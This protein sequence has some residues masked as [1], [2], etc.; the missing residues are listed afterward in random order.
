MV[1]VPSACDHC[2]RVA[3]PVEH[4]AS[5]ATARAS[6]V[7]PTCPHSSPAAPLL[8]PSLLH[9]A[10]S[11]L[12]CRQHKQLTRRASPPPPPPPP[13]PLLPRVPRPLTD[14]SPRRR[15]PPPWPR[16]RSDSSRPRTR[17]AVQVR[18]HTRSDSRQQRATK[19]NDR[20]AET[21]RT[22]DRRPRPWTVLTE[23]A[24]RPPPPPPPLSICVSAPCPC[25]H[26]RPS[27]PLHLLAQPDHRAKQHG[28]HKLSDQLKHVSGAGRGEGAT[29]RR[30]RATARRRRST[31]ALRL[32]GPLGEERLSAALYV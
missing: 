27:S 4:K 28:D 10:A 1:L 15:L 11:S 21:R 8:S 26:P 18:N 23:P 31:T 13:P 25:R 7:E 5:R 6:R 16:R 17:S 9:S 2:R 12:L 14:C 32:L 30:A 20:G 24:P 3:E 29:G 22:S 19:K